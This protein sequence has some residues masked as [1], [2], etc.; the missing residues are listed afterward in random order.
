MVQHSFTQVTRTSW[1]GRMGRSF[2][3]I[4]VGI[5]L[6]AISFPVLW[7]NEG[8]A[9]RRTRDLREGEG[10]VVSIDAN[11][12][13]AEFDRKLVHL[14]GR[15]DTDEL[16]QDRDFPVS[17]VALRLERQVEMYQWEERERR[18]TRRRVGGGEE[19]V[20]T[21]SYSKTWSPRVIR[22]SQFRQ[23]GGHENPTRM[24]YEADEVLAAN[25]EL[26]AYR[27][28]PAQVR[29]ISVYE[30]LRVDDDV[31]NQ[32]PERLR[33]RAHV[34]T[35]GLYIGANPSDPQV[36]DLRISFRF[37]PPT[38]VSIVSRRVGN[39]FEPFSARYGTI[40]LLQTGIVSAER[41]LEAAHQANT[42]LTWILRFV[43]LF[44]MMMGLR[45][46][47]E[48][49]AVIADVIPLL[50]NILRMG[51]GIFSFVIALALSLV[52]VAIAWIAYR[53][54]VGGS[55]L[56]LAVACVVV[57]GQRGKKEAAALEPVSPG[58]PPPTP[59]PPPPP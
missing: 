30:S 17:A 23:P 34:T 47:L 25:V 15:A 51:S 48:P 21:Y 40:D 28:A 35:D 42:A 38:D 9:V 3:G 37:V 36:G 22:S 12:T 55:L 39:T 53:P 4:L 45:L 58:A 27:L 57:V 59:P 52:T 54:L 56:A 43:G 44:L 7:I 41:M 33:D 19:T 10:Q 1:F 5:I 13:A 32:L 6:F 49:L 2:K 26:G 16:L 11:D 8:R 24:E 50:G 18:E 46:V 20:T 14:S 29:R 31:I